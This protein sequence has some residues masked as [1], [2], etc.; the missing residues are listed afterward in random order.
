MRGPNYWS[1]RRHKLIVMVL[2]LEELENQPTNKIPGFLERLK[3]MFP[4]MYEHRCSENGPGGFFHR[5]EEGTWMGHV[6]EH[7]ALEIQ[8]LAGMEVGFGRTRSY[9]E[10]GVYHVVFAYEEEKVGIYAARAAVRMAEALVKGEPYDIAPDIQEM[11]ETREKERLGPSTGSLIEEAIARGIPWIRLNRY[12][13]CQLGYGANQRRIQATVTSQTSSIGV[14]L[15]C[16]KEDTK[17][18]LQNAEIPVPKGEII[19]TE[20]GLR[21]AID[22]MG[23]PIVLKPINGNHGRGITTNINTWEDALIGFEAAKKVSNSVIIERF[24]TGHDYRLLV[25]NY[26]L[27]AAAKRTPAHV[28]GDGVST[29]KQLIDKV[30]EDPRRGYGHENVLT[31]IT[32]DQMTLDL[33]TSNNLTVDSVPEKGKFVKLKD[34]ANLSTGGTATDVTD[35]VHPQNIFMAERIARIIGLDICGIDVMTPDISLPVDKTGGA[36]LEVNAAPGFRMHLAP[37]DGLPRNVAAHVIDMLYP[38]GSNFRIP[39]VAVTGT[40]GKTTTTRLIAHMAKMRGFKVGYT[41][42][43][44]VYIQ[45]HLLV[46]GDCTGPVSAEF[47]LKDPTVDFAVLECARGGLLRAGLG[48]HNC[49]IGI[50]TNVAPD[51]LGLKGIHTVEQLAKV[52]GVIPESVLPNGHAIL[53][54]D[55]DLVYEM[56]NNVKCNVALFSMD[57]NNPRI[58]DHAS[59]GGLSAIFEDG[60]ITICK[61]EWKMRVAKAVNVPLTYGGK[62]TFMIQ[63]ILPAVLTGYLRGF[64]LDDIKMALDTFIPSPTQTP[65]RINLFNFRDFQV[66][67]DYAHNAAGL[68][69]LQ[70]MVEKMD[71][72]PK[73]GVIAGV[74]DRRDDDIRDIGRVAAE[75]YDEIIIRQDK[76]L[77]GRTEQEIISLLGEGIAQHD[78]NKKVTII[79]SEKEAIHHAITNAT[80]GSLIVF[81]SDVVPDALE[82][83]M[84]YKEE[85]ANRLYEFKPGTDIP[86]KQF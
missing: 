70:K 2:D 75:T 38:P 67:V 81:C 18:L 3:A 25:I 82:Q 26:K 11:R 78:K 65:G 36:V 22:S 21:E 30:N 53:N 52:K 35:I 56:R 51:H 8:S 57:E 86:N 17:F 77:R 42:T 12:S 64:P 45:N 19:K 58:K 48:F 32:I 37:T 5:V 54:A 73:I 76:N 46:K 34:T 15:A 20:R 14:E 59:R 33:L 69:A 83:I 68:R 66:L 6:I 40:N 50:V 44:G 71:A 39:I 4:G 43:D 61:G 9:G 47:V 13:L 1:I 79:P 84:A 24:I 62:A 80:K 10:E 7:I 29:I 85:E 16:D 49:D 72:Y 31:Q 41:T 55:D 60:Y 27:V 23:Y 63:N 28:I 74:G